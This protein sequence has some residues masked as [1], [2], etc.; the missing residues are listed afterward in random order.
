MHLFPSQARR[1]AR[2]SQGRQGARPRFRQL[3]ELGRRT[4]RRAARAPEQVSG[5]WT[6]WQPP[7]GGTRF[8]P[9]VSFAPSLTRRRDFAIAHE[10]CTFSEFRTG[11]HPVLLATDLAQRGLDIPSVTL[12]VNFD[13]PNEIT[14]YVHRFVTSSRTADRTAVDLTVWIRC[15]IGRTGR[16]GHTGRAIT[17][18]SSSRDYRKRWASLSIVRKRGSPSAVR[19]AQRSRRRS[20]G[21]S[22][23]ASNK[24][25][26]N[27]RT[28]SPRAELVG[29]LGP[30]KR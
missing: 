11:T 5:A 4:R 3:E 9:R 29:S 2:R 8:R 18:L 7:A 22:A 20:K 14:S 21:S 16:A 25:R 1:L 15:S 17:F 23:R 12:V 27:S 6:A 30:V 13:A 28:T 10:Y 19:N 26:P 24:S